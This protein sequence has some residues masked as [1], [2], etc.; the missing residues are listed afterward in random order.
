MT[1]I[2]IYLENEAPHPKPIVKELLQLINQVQKISQ[3]IN[4]SLVPDV[5]AVFY[6]KM[7][8]SVNL[9]TASGKG[10]H[11]YVFTCRVEL[12]VLYHA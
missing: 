2:N 6:M 7:M 3:Y 12:P 1:A 11:T 10:K 9:S 5:N 4:Y 8:M